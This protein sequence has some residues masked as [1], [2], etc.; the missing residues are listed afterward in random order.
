MY[1]ESPSPKAHILTVNLRLIIRILLGLLSSH[2]CLCGVL[3]VATASAHNYFMASTA[4]SEEANDGSA[5]RA[6][7]AFVQASAAGFTLNG[8]RFYSAGTNGYSLALISNGKQYG[9][10]AAGVNSYFAMQQ[11]Q[12]LN[13]IRTWMFLNGD[14]QGLTTDTT[15]RAAQITPGI[16]NETVLQRFDNIIA[17]AG[18]YNMKLICTLSNFPE[19]LGGAQWYV[20]QVLGGSKPSLGSGGSINLWFSNNKVI[21]AF[22]SYVKML[23]NRKNTITGR[24]YKDEPA[25]MAWEIC[26]EPEHTV[27]GQPGD[28]TGSL[29]MHPGQGLFATPWCTA[30]SKGVDFAG[31]LALA[32]ISFGTVHAYPQLFAIPFS[33]LG[34]YDNYTWT[35]TYFIASRAAMAKSVGKPLILEEFGTIPAGTTQSA[36]GSSYIDVYGLGVVKSPR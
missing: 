32:N 27:N 9:F 18:K 35:N 12:N 20:D 31:N 29:A 4:G 3:N 11:A 22:Q 16:Y 30:G 36:D 15:D 28:S 13:T 17:A 8:Q 26:N 25:I 5:A 21:E 10:A 19:E 7:T 6:P 1:G 23:I 14:G 33:A 34:D 24:L 2:L